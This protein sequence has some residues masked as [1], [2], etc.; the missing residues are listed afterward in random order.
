MFPF[1]TKSVKTEIISAGRS[2]LE[3]SEVSVLSLSHS[4]PA[5]QR[6]PAMH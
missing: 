6:G 3:S 1:K 5:T 4:E 2:H